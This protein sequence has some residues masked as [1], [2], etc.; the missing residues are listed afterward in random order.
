V[1][2]N[3]PFKSVAHSLVNEEPLIDG[4]KSGVGHGKPQSQAGRSAAVA[5]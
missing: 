1:G 2:L 5:H 3:H 4:A